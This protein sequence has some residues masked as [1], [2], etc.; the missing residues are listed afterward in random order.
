M[1]SGEAFVKAVSECIH[2]NFGN[3][4]IAFDISCVILSLLL[5][6]LFFHFS[7]VGIREGTVISALCTGMVV[8]FFTK[9]LKKPLTSILHSK[10]T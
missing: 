2:K 6:L 7:I 3:V 4:K 1:N 10:N 5:S 8:K 9:Y